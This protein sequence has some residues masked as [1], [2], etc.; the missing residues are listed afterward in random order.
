[1]DDFTPEER[2][3]MI[4]TF[5][6]NYFPRPDNKIPPPRTEED[7]AFLDRLEKF[8]FST[9]KFIQEIKDIL[10]SVTIEEFERNKEPFMQELSDLIEYGFTFESETEK[11]ESACVSFLHDK[12]KDYKEIIEFMDNLPEKSRESAAEYRDLN[13]KVYLDYI[14][15]LVFYC[16]EKLF[17]KEPKRN[18]TH[19]PIANGKATKAIASMNSRGM[20]PD[21]I[22][23]D[24]TITSNEVKL[25]IEKFNSLPGTLGISTHKLLYKAISEFTA[26]NHMGNVS[27]I[28]SYTVKFPLK[29]YALQCGYDIE[30]HPASTPEEAEQERKRIKNTLDNFR[31]KVKKDIGLLLSFRL[32]WEENIKGKPYSFDSMNIMGRGAIKNGIVDIEFTV[33]MAEYLI[34]LPMSQYPVALFGVD[35]RNTNA[36]IIGLK[37]AEHYNN[38]NN[39]IAGTANLLRV[40]SLLAYTSFPDLDTVRAD[41]NSWELRIKEPFEHSLDVLTQSGVLADWRY[42]HSKGA[43]MS[44]TEAVNFESYEEWADTLIY[45]ELKAPIDHTERLAK[46]ADKKQKNKEKNPR[47][48]KKSDE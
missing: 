42:S 26:Q 20:K 35:E 40:K 14:E 39:L 31:K 30:E 6:L 28:K 3:E 4:E 34:Q 21:R 37:M 36:Y 15:S 23:G 1:M 17:E 27:G 5:L 13:Y 22:T 33:S 38:D 46:I 9:E 25:A 2:K 44:D 24:L 10:N 43:E 8:M 11:E 48:K 19:L 16:A 32:T 29:E 18:K 12:I 45:F 41:E 47:K 7:K